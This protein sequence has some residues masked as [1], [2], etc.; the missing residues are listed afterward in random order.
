MDL[1]RTKP[2]ILYFGYF[3]QGNFS[4]PI[5]PTIG[6]LWVHAKISDFYRTMFY[7]TNSLS[8]FIT[9]KSFT[10]DPSGFLGTRSSANNLYGFICSFPMLAPCHKD[11]PRKNPWKF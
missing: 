6:A 1:V 9:S 8:F 3:C 4:F 2:G 10:A 5:I 7:L 11:T